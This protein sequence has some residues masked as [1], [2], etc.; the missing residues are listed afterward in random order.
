MIRNR[1]TPDSRLRNLNQGL[2]VCDVEVI[3]LRHQSGG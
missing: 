3:S 2:A 1:N